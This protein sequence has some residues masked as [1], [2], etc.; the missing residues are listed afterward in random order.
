MKSILKKVIG[1]SIAV[2]LFGGLLVACKP[3]FNSSNIN[4][5]NSGSNSLNSES[6]DTSLE[7]NDELTARQKEIYNLAKKTGYKGSYEEWL[8]SIRGDSVQLIIEGKTLKWKYSQENEWIT[9]ISLEKFAGKDGEDGKKVL[10]Q[11]NNGFI[12]YQYEGDSNW[13]NLLDLSLINGVNNGEVPN[14]SD[15]NVEAG[16]SFEYVNKL[17]Y[18]MTGYYGDL[19]NLEIP[20]TYKGEDVIGIGN[21]A[22]G[23]YVTSVKLSKNIKYIDF[24]AFNFAENLSELHLEEMN[25]ISSNCYGLTSPD[26]K[27][28]YI[29]NNLQNIDEIIINNM[30]I[31]ELNYSG[32]MDEWNSYVN[33]DLFESVTPII[34]CT[35]GIIDFDMLIPKALGYDNI[36]AME[37]AVLGAYDAKYR[38]ATAIKNQDRVSERYQK[39]AE[40]EYGLIY[41]EGLIV[42]MYTNSGY[43]AIVS[44]T[45]PWQAGRA[46]YGLTTD[47][48][49]NVVVTTGAMTKENRENVTMAYENGK[50]QII[51]PTVDS[52]GFTSL[53]DPFSNPKLNN[54]KYS[55]GAVEFTTKNSYNTIYQSEIDKDKLNYLKNTWTY[56]SAVYTNMVDGLVENNKYGAIVGALAESYK[57][58]TKA[59]GTQVWQFKLKEGLKWVDNKTGA[60][61]AALTAADF[62]TSAKYVLDPAN[63]SGTANLYTNFIKGASEYYEALAA[64][65]EADFSTVGV[66]SLENGTIVEYTLSEG[67]PYFNTVLTSSAYLP[68]HEDCL[69]ELGSD[70]GSTV[71]NIWVC[72]AFRVTEHTT[73]NKM[74][75]TKNASYHDTDHVYVDKV[76]LKWYAATYTRDTMRKWYEQG[77]VDSFTVQSTGDE[78]G[79]AKYVKGGNGTG[80]QKNPAHPECNA[81]LSIGDTSYVGYFNFNRTIFETHD[82]AYKK[83]NVQKL[84]TAKALLN[85]N[86]RL[87]FLYGIEVCEY[88]RMLSHDEPWN[89][90]MR[91]YTNRELVCDENGKDYTSYV[92]DVYNKKQ[93]T[94]GVSLA[95]I[96]NGSDPV[97]DDA[98]AK[99]YLEAAKAELIAYGKLSEKDFPIKID[100]ICD[101]NVQTQVYEKAMYAKLEKAG[102]G[103]IEIQYHV[104]SLYEEDKDWRYIS[105]NYDFSIIS[106]GIANY[107]DPQTYLN[108][109]TIDGD[110][111]EILGF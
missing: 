68:V 7:E 45:V 57:V 34:N 102:E 22:I 99:A 93:G 90:V 92:E 13:I 95:G 16:F 111:V 21:F 74:V 1:V 104:P 44:R 73:E 6:I 101:M 36:D 41:E 107:T 9:L 27:I 51:I 25:S 61:K 98:K 52:N 38:E 42:P 32:T 19:T 76:N 37:K 47:K 62:V 67:C 103:I 15:D 59:D 78:E 70:F 65:E 50:K 11:V 18:I 5:S 106:S 35:N 10:F 94:W 23:P 60:E 83:T 85:K 88:L 64:G 75:F 86:F 43:T 69:K 100:V 4:V 81:V 14:L 28:I 80:T 89:Y 71:N 30:N 58:E 82:T 77:I 24:Y 63:A 39:M 56:N 33:K 40:A 91:G 55:Y 48:F 108:T 12:Q 46:T 79:W 20:A 84:N 53:A 72:G 110:M 8:N 3:I 96:V 17:G 97:F 49:K 109:M 29:S 54:G 66:K 31:Y 2:V 105:H 26:V 87:A